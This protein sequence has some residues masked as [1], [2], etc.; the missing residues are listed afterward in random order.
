VNTTAAVFRVVIRRLM[1]RIKAV[2]GEQATIHVFPAI[3]VA[4]SVELGCVIMPKADLPVL[5]Y[6]QNRQLGGFSFA[7]EINRQTEFGAAQQTHPCASRSD[8]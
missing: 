3:P 6:D 4:A 1:D 7:L 8:T 5:I 2:H